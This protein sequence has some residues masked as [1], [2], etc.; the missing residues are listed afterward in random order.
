LAISNIS[1]EGGNLTSEKEELVAFINFGREVCILGGVGGM[2][3]EIY[4]F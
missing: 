3:E 1:I 4:G 2:E